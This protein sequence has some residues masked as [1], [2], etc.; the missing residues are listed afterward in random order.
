MEKLK[1]LLTKPPG[2][3]LDEFD[4]D[5]N[6]IR[7]Y[8]LYPPAALATIAASALKKV[9]NVEIEI[10]DLE[11][12]ILKY[13]QENEISA[14]STRDAMKKLIIDKME[15]FSPDLCGITVMFSPSHENA[16]KVANIVKQKKQ[17]I[18]IICGGNHATF[19]YKRML[20][21]CQSLDFIFLYEGDHTFQLFL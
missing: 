9:S 2:F 6:K 13:F 19:A 21:K 16:L 10:L 14:L 4:R 18:K 7:Y 8:D 17:N 15:Q 11:F 5:Q 1:I 3:N 12:E 20:E